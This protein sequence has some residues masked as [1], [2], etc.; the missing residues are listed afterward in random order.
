MAFTEEHKLVQHNDA[1]YAIFDGE[2]EGERC[3]G[4][5]IVIAGKS[6]RM[7]VCLPGAPTDDDLLDSEP[8]LLEWIKE[9]LG[10]ELIRRGANLR[11]EADMREL[12]D[13]DPALA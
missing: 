1:T 4:V 8:L 7:A 9:K 10:D 12:L 3:I 5:E 11:D 2:K 13:G 6:H